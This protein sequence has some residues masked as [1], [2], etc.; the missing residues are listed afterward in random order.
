MEHRIIAKIA[1]MQVLLAITI[2]AL[3]KIF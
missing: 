2:A 1:G 3:I